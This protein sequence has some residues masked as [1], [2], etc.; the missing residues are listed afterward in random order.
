MQR[1]GRLV[2]RSV[3]VPPASCKCRETIHKCTPPLTSLCSCCQSAAWLTPPRG[4]TLPCSLCAPPARV[5]QM[6]AGP[7]VGCALDA[8]H[9]LCCAALCCAAVA[10]T[11]TPEDYYSGCTTQLSGRLLP[12]AA[13]AA[14][15]RAVPTSV[16]RHL[17]CGD[18]GRR[19]AGSQFGPQQ[20]THGGERTPRAA[21][22]CLIRRRCVRLP[23]PA[24]AI[25]QILIFLFE[26]CACPFVV[27]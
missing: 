4:G 20:H 17:T 25:N 8:V 13:A 16:A 27:T 26:A 3:V 11:H 12:A 21:G 1:G 9:V 10:A 15:W 2:P 6:T 22:L 23:Q 14:A 5:W 7:H 19:Q 24:R 18:T